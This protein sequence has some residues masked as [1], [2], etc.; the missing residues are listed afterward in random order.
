MIELIAATVGIGAFL[1]ASKARAKNGDE[2]KSTQQLDPSGMTRGE[3]NNNPGNIRF[4][5]RWAWQGQVG[6][7]GG[8]YLIFDTPQNGVRAMTR[9]LLAKITRGENTITKILYIYAPPS[10]N[11][12]TQDYIASVSG[13][14]GVGKDTPI[15]PDDKSRITALVT[16]MIRFENA[17]VFWPASVITAGVLEGM[18]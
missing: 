4:D 15:A 1:Y 9:D 8:D 5:I 7:D 3:R 16:A 17:R 2:M 12:P 13:W 14:S 6:K 11:N 10:D 18:K